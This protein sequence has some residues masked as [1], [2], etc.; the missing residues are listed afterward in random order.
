MPLYARVSV[1]VRTIA[2]RVGFGADIAKRLIDYGFHAPT[3]SWPVGGTLMVEPTES[4]SKCARTHAA[5][6]R[7]HARAH[8]HARTHISTLTR[9]RTPARA[10]RYELDRFCDAMIA[11][12]QEIREVEAGEM[13]KDDNCLK[14]A[15]HTVQVGPGRVG[16]RAG[17]GPGQVGPASSPRSLALA[18][19]SFLA[20]LG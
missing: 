6:A 11:I 3:M 1:H 20:C 4:E 5:H 18:P 19:P 7:T 12:R 2:L 15:P 16:P 14:N 8:A 10:C 13:H 17:W 9:T